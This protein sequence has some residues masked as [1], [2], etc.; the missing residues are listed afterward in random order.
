MA[1]YDEAVFY[2]MYPLGLTGA[3]KQNDYGEPV[4]RLNTLL[5]WIDHIK[6]LGFTALYIGPLFQSV[7]HGYETT[8]YK[9]LDSRLGTND[10]LVAFVR[11]CHDA[12]IK[13]VF[14]GVFNHTGRDFFAF[15]D[16]RQNRE[17]SPYRDWYCNV[18]FWGNNEYNDGFSYDN[19]GG[20]NLL[21]KLNQRNP[22]VRDYICDVI[23][24]WVNTFDVDGIRLD[25]ADVL[26]FDFMKALRQTADA[27]K[28]D[29]WLMGEVIHGDYSRWA[30]EHTLHSVTDYAL[31]KAFFSG[32]ND[33]NYFEIAHTVRRT[34]GMVPAHIRLYKFVDNHDV[35]RIS[36]KLR[37]K[38]HYLPVHILL[39]TLPGIPSVYYGSEFGIEGKKERFSD[40]S[41]RPHIDLADYADAYET[42]PCTKLTAALGK[43]YAEHKDD[44]VWGAYQELSLTTEQYAYARGNLI[45]ALNNAEHEVTIE[46]GAN[47]PAYVGLLSGTTIVV[48]GGRL[49]IALPACGGDIF[50]PLDSKPKV[51]KPKADASEAVKPSNKKTAKKA[52]KPAPKDGLIESFAARA[53]EKPAEATAAVADL[54]KDIPNV[55]YE[56]MTVEQLQAV[57]LSKMAK[58]GPVTDQMTR[59][60]MNNIW[61]DSLVNWA[62]SFR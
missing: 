45:I 18:N 46:V 47:A 54:P 28:P 34:N 44:L 55:P 42:N 15:K 19:W 31:H 12:G 58:N 5:P 50:A 52:E 2:H 3:P 27:V 25:A 4:H 10:D 61:Q 59:D 17:N 41:L 14:D 32:H 26:D 16:I 43:I 38:A 49:R 30:N 62:K 8:D 24:F 51:E 9:L 20:Y 1:W 11:A 40:D 6:R 7:G 37:N 36:T 60:V 53:E 48:E 33:H 21:A 35:E 23:R 56:Q 13:V 22:A 39:Y 29:F 57:I